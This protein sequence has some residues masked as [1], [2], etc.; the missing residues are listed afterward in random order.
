MQSQKVAGSIPASVTLPNQPKVRFINESSQ[1][2]EYHSKSGTESETGDYTL[3]NMDQRDSILNVQFPMPFTF[4]K[5]YLTL[6]GVLMLDNTSPPVQ[7]QNIAEDPDEA[8]CYIITH[9]N[10]NMVSQSIQ[11]F[12]EFTFKQVYYSTYID[13]SRYPCLQYL[14]ELASKNLWNKNALAQQWL[15]TQQRYMLSDNLSPYLLQCLL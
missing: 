11:K 5:P 6:N 8:L 15:A 14:I 1:N 4:P 12:P 10:I 7:N 2:M 3:S 9:F 13:I